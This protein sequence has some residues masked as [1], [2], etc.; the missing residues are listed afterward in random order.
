LDEARMVVNDQLYV[1]AGIDGH[2]TGTVIDFC[3]VRIKCRL[4]KLNLKDFMALAVQT[5]ASDN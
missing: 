5:T 3:T 1:V 2:T 4:V